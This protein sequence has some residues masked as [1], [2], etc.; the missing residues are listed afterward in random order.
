MPFASVTVNV[1][2]LLPVLLQLKLVFD[3][4]MLAIPQLSVLP[5]LTTPVV[6]VAFPVASKFRAI[7]E[8]TITVG[9]VVS[10]IVMVAL[11]VAM[12][13]FTSVTVRTTL[14]APTLLQLK[15]VLDKPMVL[16]LQLSLEPL[17]T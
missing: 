17:F 12:F 5:L 2:V 14:F 7:G 9:L 8:L 1:T 16:M 11:A 13:P 3:K 6:K 10:A 15:L 4:V